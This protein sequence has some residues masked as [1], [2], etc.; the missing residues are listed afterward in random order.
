MTE[1][2]PTSQREH[3]PGDAGAPDPAG[4]GP[5]APSP[6]M[7]RAS[8]LNVGNM[9][10]SILPLVV[11]CLVIVAWTTWRQ[12]GDEG[13]RTVDPSSTIQLASARASYPVPAP[14]GLPEDYLVTS[15]RTDA[16]NAGEGD[17]VTLEIGYLTPSEEYAG[18]VVSDDPSAGAIVD[19]VG[20]AEEQGTVRIGGQEWQRLTTGR[21]ETALLR[22][23]DGVVVAVTGSASDEELETVAQAVEP[24]S[25]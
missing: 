7:Q 11:I 16:G 2:G 13:V 9:M 15:A 21:G 18:F 19:V 23:S 10:R 22:E 20:E 5:A 3:T 4:S 6:T 24:Y 14:E 1:V 17:P 8:R 12:S 25:P